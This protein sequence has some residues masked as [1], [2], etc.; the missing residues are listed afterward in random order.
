MGEVCACLVRD[1]VI[2]HSD[3]HAF[4]QPQQRPL[5]PC[6]SATGHEACPASRTHALTHPFAADTL[7]TD[8]SMYTYIHTYIHTYIR[9][10]RSCSNIKIRLDGWHIC[11]K[12]LPTSTNAKQS[13]SPQ[14]FRL[15]VL[16]D[17]RP[18]PKMAGHWPKSLIQRAH[19]EQE[20]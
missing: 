14:A 11:V 8:S 19:R 17:H 13:V 18:R 3:S 4:I 5:L 6:R 12:S 7:H 16:P 2:S 20:D 10:R 9:A 15:P 1:T